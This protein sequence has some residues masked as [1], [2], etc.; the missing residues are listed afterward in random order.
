MINEKLFIYSFYKFKKIPNKKKIK[1]DIDQILKK[2]ILRG[3]I[4]IA[5]EG[6]NASISGR[7]EDLNIIVSLLKKKLRIRYL[8][9]KKQT[10]D[11]LPFNRMKVRLKKEIVS[12]GKGEIKIKQNKKFFLNPDKWNQMI[13]EKGIKILDVRNNF[14]IDI[15]KFK[16]SINPRTKS[17][18]EF[19]NRFKELGIEKNDKIA[20]YCTGGIRC[21]KAS[22][23][24][25]SQGYKNIVQLSGGII[26]Y[27]EYAKNNQIEMFWDGDC[28]V[29]DDR[30][31]INKDLSKG[32]YDQC[33]G[34][35]HPLKSYEKKLKSYVKGVSCKYCYSDR[36]M[37]QKNKSKIR[38][39]Q[40][41]NDKKMKR[42]NSFKKLSLSDLL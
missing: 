35:K 24:L 7:E 36:S 27:L 28:F 29:F 31:T 13:N 38:Q 16:N 3:T 10:V 14:E 18:R 1:F 19:P 21:E 6:V 34:C 12:F 8:N 15:G 22:S 23:Y 30:V 11:F 20:M 33:Y 26:N 4:L 2:I 41:D 17:F 42:N 5:N 32:N 40:I 37:S 9:I 39:S 25:L